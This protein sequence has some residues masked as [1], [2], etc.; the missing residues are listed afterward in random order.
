MNIKILKISLI[1]LLVLLAGIIIFY[2]WIVPAQ[3]NSLLQTDRLSA[4]VEQK[5]GFKLSYKNAA[6]ETFPSLSI[7]IFAE[8]ISLKDRNNNSIL[9]AKNADISLFLPSLLLKKITVK[10]AAANDLKFILTRKKDKK[11]YLGH[12]PLN[13]DTKQK[14]DADIN[15]FHISNSDFILKDE[16]INKQLDIRIVNADISYKKNKKV[17]A[18][19]I[20]EI[21]VNSKQKSSVNIDF[22]SKLPLEHGL[23]QN[24]LR[25]HC[26]IE[27]IDLSDFSGYLAFFANKDIVSS[28]GIINI[29][30]NAHNA[31]YSG[32]AIKADAAITDFSINMKNPLDNIRS[33]STIY[34]D[35]ILSFDKKSLKITDTK[36]NAKDWQINLSG[37]IKDYTSSNPKADLSVNIPKSDIHSMYWLVPSI[38]D[39]PF[40]VMQKFKKYGAWGKAQGNLQIKGSLLKPE[41][42]GNLNA[43]D[44]YIVK[45]NPLVPHCKIFA[46]FLKDNVKVKT[47]VFAGHG[48]Y[49]DVEGIAEMK[50]YGAGDFH[51]VSSKN[52][53]LS[54]AEYMLVPV[55]EV[56]GFDLGP[57]PYMDIKGKGDIDIRT[58]GTILDGDVIGQ[59][60]FRNTYA[61]LEGLNTEIENANGALV[62][63]H[64]NMH[65]YT[66]SAYIKHQPVKID[67]KANLDGHIDFDVD[68]ENI[69]ISDLFH[70]LT[71]SAILDNK[72]FMVNPV[73]SV[74]G[75][76][77]A[78]IKIKGIVKD[79]SK[80]AENPTFKISGVL[81][82]KGIKGK[83][84]Y[85]PV[86]AQN[87]KG[88]INFDDTNWHAVLN[89]LT[90]TSPIYIQGGSNNGKTDLKIN[91]N[92]L[93]TDE[94]IPF[95]LL[96]SEEKTLSL[97]KTNSYITFNGRYKSS[98]DNFDLKNL[99]ATG[100]FLP[101]NQKE[102][103]FIISS[104]NFEINRGNLTLKNFNAKLYGSQIK[105]HGTVHNF[106]SKE[107]IADGHLKVSDFNI[108]AFDKIKRLNI[109]P[110]SIYKLLNAYENYEGRINLSID[111]KHNNLNGYIDLKDIKFNHSY[112]KTPISIDSGKILL[113]GKK[114]TLRSI[115][116]QVDNTPVFLNISV[117]DL[118]KTAKIKGYL[119]TKINENFV[120][121]YINSRLTYPIKIKGDISLTADIS[122][123]TENI[124]LQPKLK[125]AP[126]SDIYYMGA[127]I[128]DENETRELSADIN[129]AA[130]NIYYLKNF[131]Y[132][133][134]MTS[135]NTRSYPLTVLT[136]NGIIHLKKQNIFIRNLNVKTLNKANAKIFNIIFKKSVLKNGQFSCNLNIK[137]D[138]K[139]PQVSGSV[140][141]DNL[142]MPL[143]DTVIK[144]ISLNFKNKIIELKTNGTVLDSDFVISAELKN[145]LKPPIVINNLDME[146]NKLNIDAFID[147][148]TR[149]PT[150]D[151][152]VRLVDNN[153]SQTALPLNISDFRIKKGKMKASDVTIRNLNASNYEAK[154]SLKDDMLL[155]ME[156][157]AF[158]VTTGQMSGSAL[159]DFSTGKIKAN[160]TALNVDSNKVASAM[161]EFKDQ[162]FG[163]A[164]GNITITTSGNTEEERLRNMFGYVYFEIADGKMPKLGSVEYLLRAGNFIKSGITGA[165]ISNFLD[166]IA[167]IKTGYFDSIKGSFT[168]K[169][170]VAQNIE[171]YSKGN[172][173]NIY[174]NGEF[175][176]LQQYANMRV[177]GRLTKHATNLLGKI[178]NLSFNTLLSKIPGFKLGNE[179]KAKIIQ[180]LN[181]IPGVELSDQQYRVFTVKI[182]GKID[183]DKYVKNFR[184][185]E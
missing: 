24:D 37:S 117:W 95:I 99:S 110:Q 74:S 105:A 48:E 171:V 50:F 175:D 88:K 47:R 112:F 30:T 140:Y 55:H 177:Y 77:K 62:F 6:I 131:K 20:S 184:W 103:D 38:K 138:I 53:D 121:K 61:T 183:E 34:I 174:I 178:G 172:N 173:L 14:I 96:S 56:I 85:I 7:K 46:E 90:G 167:P 106:F 49:V 10:S 28:G 185:I 116:A 164:N 144:D 104:G 57:V 113:E 97:P 148:L 86:Y 102:S 159:Y 36:I 163:N 92:K 43:E 67:G 25:C 69:E 87:L 124:R 168:V 5:T 182:D 98:N 130:N 161:F 11:F 26:N 149:I 58:K 108:S 78:D 18:K 127:N 126:D 165:S 118:D 82:L 8:N 122:G 27:N 9:C 35:S 136:A 89:G 156:R 70:I 147:S 180:D 13:L 76:V 100:Y 111:C 162:I 139:Y 141:M 19:I 32:N 52:V 75:K 145:N 179:D 150:P 128:G 153:K 2:L 65:F 12:L 132:T 63:D 73:E 79:F 33:N 3:L 91:A 40:N 181:K 157:L 21:L 129:V 16:L 151:T 31:N 51:I 115:I 15:S 54:T 83:L 60:N 4:A 72:K 44:V 134:Y 101:I 154:F 45:N 114:A 17:S 29:K 137:G 133:R 123:N 109:L 64:K 1:S 170:G 169:N 84:K 81:D 142:D 158:D 152:T 39:D 68:A 143:Y 94:L 120:N 146:S 22:S 59:F 135:Q 42:Y 160:V 93:K 176:I 125:L 119:T 155:N 80:I 107:Y 41:L 71:T 66:N 166:L 23:R